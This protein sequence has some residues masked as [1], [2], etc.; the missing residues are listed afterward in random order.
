VTHTQQQGINNV[1]FILCGVHPFYQDM[2]TE[3]HGISRFIYR[4]ID[5]P[6]L[7]PDESSELLETKFSQVANLAEKQGINLKIDPDII[8]RIINLS[9]GHP[10]IIQLL[11]SHIIEHECEDPDDIIDSNDLVNS[12]QKIC[13]EDRGR[14]YDDIFHT[15]DLNDMLE[16]FLKILYQIPRGFPSKITQKILLDYV[17]PNQIKWLVKQN[18]ISNQYGYYT[19][20]DEFLRIRVFLEQDD[21]EVSRL[22]KEILKIEDLNSDDFYYDQFN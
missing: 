13:F 3:D 19:L 22:E 18:I 16:P 15:L 9:G 6:P 8:T 5:L 11:G 20:V 21:Y 2:I 10:H 4:T 17:E 7:L 14:V 1:R 12:L